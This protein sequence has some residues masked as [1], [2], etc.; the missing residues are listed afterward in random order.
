MYKTLGLALLLTY[1]SSAGQDSPA[2]GTPMQKTSYALGMDLGKQLRAASLA[3]D[4]ALFG[5]GLKDALSG[6]ETLLSDEQVHAIISELQAA[7]KPHQTGPKTGSGEDNSELE[8]MGSYNA[9]KGSAFLA[10]NAK[11]EGVVTLPSGLQYRILRAGTGRKPAASDTVLCNFRAS[12]LEGAE[13]DDTFKRPEPKALKVK[14]TIKALTEALQ[15]MPTGS[16]WELVVPPSL[17][18]GET[19]VGPIGPNATL[20]YELELLSIQ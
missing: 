4:P 8:M 16:R 9:A 10:A 18:Y 1:G 15:L 2:L 12:L 7:R 11:K 3:V 19:G 5:R 17:A 20:R 6:G 13:L 14:E